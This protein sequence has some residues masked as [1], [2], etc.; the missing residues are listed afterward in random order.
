MKVHFL[1][2]D[3]LVAL[4]TNISGN[5]KHYA[6]ETN[7]W[8]YEYFGIDNPFREY[9]HDFPD[10]RLSFNKE[11][12]GK[13]DVDNTIALYSA[14]R[15]L[16]V[17]E[18]SDE[19]LWAGMCHSNFWSFLRE[20]WQTNTIRDLKDS[21]VKSRY[22]FGQ[23]KRRSFITN[24]LAKLWWIG[25]LTYDE[26]QKD[27]FELTK[28]L[29][30]NFSTKSLIIFSNNYMSNPSVAKGVLSALKYLNDTGY[31]IKGNNDKAV[32]IEATKYL[33]VL[34]GTCVLDYFTTDEI[35]DRVIKYMENNVKGAIFPPSP[36][37]LP[38][39]Y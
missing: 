22:F 28:Y 26:R 36:S 6:D 16:T 37:E 23:D 24:S 20:R 39:F 21:N 5:L 19:R 32:Y 33:N 9:K 8:I 29:T 38:T 11:E 31:K 4:K 30:K 34:G 13:I 25:H 7:E 12:I 35:K 27:P 10:I 17:T 3:A 14:M 15:T 18:A 1:T 2:E